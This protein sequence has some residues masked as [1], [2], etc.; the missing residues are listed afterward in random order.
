MYTHPHTMQA[1]V[2]S[3][4]RDLADANH[5]HRARRSDRSNNERRAKSSVLKGINLALTRAFTARLRFGV[6]PAVD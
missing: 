3:H 5:A 4:R 2:A 1:L 6:T